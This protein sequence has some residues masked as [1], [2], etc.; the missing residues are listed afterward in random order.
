MFL[1]SPSCRTIA[2][3]SLNLPRLP[4]R[5]FAFSLR[6]FFLLLTAFCLWLGWNVNLVQQRKA[7]REEDQVKRMHLTLQR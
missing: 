6:G 2:A 7:I 5:W 3:M 1:R 4:W